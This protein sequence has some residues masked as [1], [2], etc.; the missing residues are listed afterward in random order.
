MEAED[1]D[2]V[3]NQVDQCAQCHRHHA[4]AAEALGVDEA[5]HAQAHHHKGGAQQIDVQVIPGEGPGGVAGAEQIQ[6]GLHAQIAHRHQHKAGGQQHHKAVAHDAPRP[7]NVA[8]AAGDA[9]Q[10]CAAGAEQVGERRDDVHDGKGQAD[11][12]EGQRRVGGQVADVHPVHHIIKHLNGLGQNQGNGHGEDVAPH[13]T[14]GEGVVGR[15]TGM[16]GM[17]RGNGL[18]EQIRLLSAR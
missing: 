17:V 15:G 9:A 11:A 4:H 5:V 14:L 16:I 8:L 7:G 10:G 13:G 2:G 1:E 18:H 6:N 3:Q 12:G